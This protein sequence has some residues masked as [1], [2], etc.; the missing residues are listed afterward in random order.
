MLHALTTIT[1]SQHCLSLDGPQVE[2]Y[3]AGVELIHQLL[4]FHVR[5]TSAL[6]PASQLPLS[7]F[8]Y[9]SRARSLSRL[10][11]S[12]ISFSL[13]CAHALWGPKCLFLLTFPNVSFSLTQMSLSR[14][15]TLDRLLSLSHTHTLFVS[16]S[17]SLSLSFCLSLSLYSLPLAR[18][19][20]PLYYVMSSYFY[21]CVFV[22]PQLQDSIGPLRILLC[23]R[24]RLYMCPHTSVYVF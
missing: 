9:L 23:V 14:S 17:L 3:I 19:L 11:P 10:G 22:C 24:I 6:S 1:T 7:L 5:S 20:A 18:A 21:I 4:V 12:N 8:L 13:V 16:L 15:R 2:V